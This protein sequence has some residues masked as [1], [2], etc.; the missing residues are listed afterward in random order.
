MLDV[1]DLPEFNKIYID[2]VLEFQSSVNNDL[3]LSATHIIIQGGRLV[4]GF[5]VNKQ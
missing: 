2:G 1:E 4:V 5:P 3:K